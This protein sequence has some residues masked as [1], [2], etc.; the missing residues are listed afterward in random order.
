MQICGHAFLFSFKRFVS[1][2]LTDFLAMRASPDQFV[3]FLVVLHVLRKEF[4]L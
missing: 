4:S 3:V 1:L 2:T